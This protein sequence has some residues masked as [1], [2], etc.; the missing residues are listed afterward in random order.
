MWGLQKKTL[1]NILEASAGWESFG[2]K[3]FKGGSLQIHHSFSG[4]IMWPFVSE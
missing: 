1:F 2:E 3:L 4:R